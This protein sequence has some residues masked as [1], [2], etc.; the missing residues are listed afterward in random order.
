MYMFGVPPIFTVSIYLPLIVDS[1][2]EDKTY[3]HLV[4]RAMR[5]STHQEGKRED[6]AGPDTWQCASK[7]C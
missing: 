4:P 3:S 7:E 2:L 1:W 5:S 6:L